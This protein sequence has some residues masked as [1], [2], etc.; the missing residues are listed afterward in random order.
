M[1]GI[2]YNIFLLCVIISMCILELLLVENIGQ[3][4]PS[5]IGNRLYEYLIA[6][7][8]STINKEDFNYNVDISVDF[9]KYLPKYIPF[10]NELYEK[11]MKIKNIEIFNNNNDIWNIPF[12]QQIEVGKIMKPS[13]SLILND[14]LQKSNVE[15]YINH[16]VIHFRCSD[17][18]FIRHEDYV[19]TKYEYFKKALE[20]MNSKLNEKFTEISIMSST[21]HTSDI[22]NKT[23]CNIY[24]DSLKTFLEKMNYKVNIISN[25]NVED[26]ATLFYAPVVISTHGTFSFMSGFFGKGLFIMPEPPVN[27]A[28]I[29][30]DDEWI[31]KGLNLSHN[32]VVDYHDTKTVI[33][34]LS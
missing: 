12:N 9:L 19:L 16:P 4:I 22:N 8:S 28:T 1:N 33:G 29:N 34:L 6:I 23:S 25:T 24:T 32:D 31:I 26:F 15:T 18:P 27:N 7:V 2:Y 17:T 30:P 21:T 14:A 5:D 3:Q 10:N 20:Y 11:L 13:F